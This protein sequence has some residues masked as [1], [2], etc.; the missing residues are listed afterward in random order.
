MASDYNKLSENLSQKF[1]KIVGGENSFSEY[2]IRWCYAFGPTV[3]EKSWMPE[4]ILMPQNTNQISKILKLANENKIPVTPRGSGTSLSAGSLSA[5]GGIILDL[6]QMN[7][8][9]SIDIENNLV[10]IEP[11]VVCDDL[12]GKLAKYGYFFPPDPGSSSV[13]TVG[14]MVAENS[15]GMQAF[16][17]GVTKDYVLSIEVVLPDGKIVNFGTNVLKSVSSYNLKDLFVGSE[18]TLGVFTKIGLRIRPAPKK[19]KLGFYIF[20]NI[21]D[22]SDSVKESRKRGIVPNLVEFL[23]KL[24][25]Q[26]VF[27]YL[28]GEFLDYPKGYVL[29]ANID[30]ND[31]N[32]IEQNFS[33]L[34]D[35][36]IRHNPLIAKI[37]V[38]DKQREDL[39]NARKAALPALARISPTCCLEDCTIKLS[40]FADVIKKIENLTK[41]LNIPSLKIATFGHMLD[42]NMHPT[43]LFNENDPKDREN[44]QAAKDYLYIEIVVPVDGS[45][46]GEHGIGKIKTQYVNLEHDEDVVE[47]MTQMKLLFDPNMI[48]NPGVGKGD[49]REII[50]SKTVRRLKNQPEKI[51]NL[52]CMRCNFC[53]ESCPSII[54]FKSEAFS[55]RGRLSI[56]NGLVHG[57][58]ELS[59]LINDIFH[60]CTLCGMCLTTCPAG[61]RTHEIFEK[62]REIMHN[63]R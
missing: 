60:A 54:F 55:P 26:A 9:I 38:D 49:K 4:L 2:E 39:I 20:E 23:D 42:G 58:L 48:L 24:T 10:E 63:L 7:K 15:G 62:A 21:D 32:E 43:F 37:A 40:D 52:N 56:L 27:E 11:G 59:E 29:L 13:C 53:K 12:N 41:Q 28:G 31:D 6:S 25:T 18:G 5:Y 34:H 14:G 44:F 33:I 50:N 46:T 19:N 35:I 51:L 61:V 16:K 22:L 3:F 47:M 45:I 17:Y 1:K 8:I 57:D 30:G 36:M